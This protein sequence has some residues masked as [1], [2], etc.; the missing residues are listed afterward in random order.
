MYE[1]IIF[2]A[3]K[4][5]EIV[6]LDGDTVKE[7]YVRNWENGDRYHPIGFA[8][9]KKVKHLFSERKVQLSLRKQLPV[10]KDAAKKILWIPGLPPA[11]HAKVKPSTKLF[12]FLIYKK[13]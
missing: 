5:A 2:G 10:I 12:V 8:H 7:F 11:D 3:Y 13:K 4:D 6:A 9:E 1:K